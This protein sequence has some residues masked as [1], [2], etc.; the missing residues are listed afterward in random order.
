MAQRPRSGPEPP[1]RRRRDRG[2]GGPRAARGAHGGFGDRRTL[3]RD[4]TDRGWGRRHG[5]RHGKPARS[6]SAA[7]GPR[8]PSR[9]A[10]LVRRRCLGTASH[11][12]PWARCPWQRRDRATLHP[13]GARP[14]HRDLG[15]QPRRARRLDHA[16]RIGL[17]GAAATR[18]V[19][20]LP[21]DRRLCR[22][23]RT[24]GLGHE[25]RLLRARSERG[26]DPRE[27]LESIEPSRH[28]GARHPRHGSRGVHATRVPAHLRGRSCPC[29]RG[30]GAP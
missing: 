12:A 15:V 25:I 20:L 2:V 8:A 1:P 6:P 26:D 29:P 27:T 14:P 28:G 21:P 10:E 17:S 5:Q 19:A 9:H 7:R 16:P 11:D 4:Q 13:S 24:A 18:R 23:G 30:A 3:R 22:L